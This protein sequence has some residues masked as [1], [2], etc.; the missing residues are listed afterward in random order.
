[1]CF[2]VFLVDDNSL[3]A[4]GKLNF[5]KRIIRKVIQKH[6][7][8]TFLDDLDYSNTRSLY[9]LKL[10]QIQPFLIIKRHF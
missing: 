2:L 10:L 9:K 1:M 4:Q 5:Y 6:L 7:L 8:S 3:T